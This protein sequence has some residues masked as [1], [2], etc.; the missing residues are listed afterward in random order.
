MSV[1]KTIVS[2]FR[3]RILAVSGTR[4][5]RPNQTYEIITGASAISG[6]IS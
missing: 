4:S 6:L 3:N 1:H 5:L 2:V